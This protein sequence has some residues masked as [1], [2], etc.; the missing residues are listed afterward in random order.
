MAKS[1]RMGGREGELWRIENE[2]VRDRRELGVRESMGVT[3]ARFRE[4]AT[5]SSSDL[6]PC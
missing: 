3:R 4:T 1:G 6:M 5:R 2:I